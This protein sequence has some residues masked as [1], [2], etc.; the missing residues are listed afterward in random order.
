M[1]KDLGHLSDV[2]AFK[3]VLHHLEHNPEIDGIINVGDEDLGK[4]AAM[5][6]NG[7][8]EEI[9]PLFIEKRLTNKQVSPE[10]AV[11]VIYLPP[12]YLFKDRGVILS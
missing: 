2:T 6:V 8:V 12:F 7:S 9:E 11:D 1:D 5:F 4:V 10:N 3:T